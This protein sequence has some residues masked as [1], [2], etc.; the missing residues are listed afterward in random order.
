MNSCFERACVSSYYWKVSFFLPSAQLRFYLLL[1]YA[2][3]DH[4]IVDE[5]R[6]FEQSHIQLSAACH[7]SLVCLG[8]RSQKEGA[9]PE[10]GSSLIFTALGALPV[11]RGQPGVREAISH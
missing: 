11:F 6:S 3:S 4:R 8:D 10:L 5:P 1:L 7:C 2:V 9:C